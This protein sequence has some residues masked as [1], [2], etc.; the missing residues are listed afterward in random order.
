MA[1]APS[2]ASPAFVSDVRGSVQKILQEDRKSNGQGAS[3]T[4]AL[5][6]G[7]YRPLY[8]KELSMARRRP[9]LLARRMGREST[10][11][12]AKAARK[13]WTWKTT[14]IA[15]ERMSCLGPSS[16]NATP[17]YRMKWMDPDDIIASE[18]VSGQSGSRISTHRVH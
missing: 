10:S 4:F 12:M 13:V 3:T 15:I 14:T 6:N 9:P 18:Y 17:P 16:H 8:S 2:L 1:D 5:W 7:M 11:P